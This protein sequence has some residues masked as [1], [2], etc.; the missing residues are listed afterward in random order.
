MCDAG[1]CARC[2]DRLI[3]Q[4]R[5]GADESSSAYGQHIHDT[6]PRDFYALDADLVTF[7]DADG[8]LRVVEHKFPGQSISGGQRRVLRLLALG[9]AELA[10]WGHIRDESGAFLYTAGAP[11]DRAVVQRITPSTTG[12]ALGPPVELTGRQLREFNTGRTIGESP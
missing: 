6:Y 10:R 11:W 3:H 12:P 8:V 2:G 4:T 9:I 5:R 7:R 1:T